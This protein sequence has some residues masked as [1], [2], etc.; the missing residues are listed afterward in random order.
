MK[1]SNLTVE[2]LRDVKA[3]RDL[4]QQSRL[5]IDIY[6]MKDEY[7][8]EYVEMFYNDKSIEYALDL[9]EDGIMSQGLCE[10]YE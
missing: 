8:V 2:M 6:P 10:Y 1:K 4:F 5:H 3:F 9:C 7:F